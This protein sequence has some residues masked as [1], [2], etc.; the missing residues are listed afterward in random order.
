MIM[1]TALQITSYNLPSVQ[2]GLQAYLQRIQQ[3]PLLSAEE[4][5]DLA[6][7]Y[8]QQGDLQAAQKL[9]LSNL[10]FVASIARTYTGYGL[11]LADLIQEGTIGLMKA[12][13][14]FDPA[15]GVRLVAFA[16]HWIKSEIHE[17]VIRNWRIVKIATT[18]AQRKLFFKLRGKKNHLA[19]FTQEEVA[20]VA[21][22]LGVLPQEVIEMES[23]L[24]SKDMAFDM[25]INEE[26]GD[27]YVVT[28]EQYLEA[29]EGDPLQALAHS[30]EQINQQAKL[31]GALE[32]LD[33]RSL[34]IVTE[35]YL[36]EE[37]SSLK[38]L[39][40]KYKVSLERIRQIEK[41][42]ILALK[43]MITTH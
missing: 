37:K 4:E 1:S 2:D 10:R 8:H 31:K 39:A 22:D 24:N 26:L 25:P 38:D 23:R 16:V 28:P 6:V 35:R 14:R 42:A 12:V 36:N 19:W 18:K 7:A 27:T 30:N 21:K 11:A 40:A 9:V 34:D 3:I 32:A 13:K 5:R 33:P 20:V 17:F 43:K 29:Q 41:S 15:L